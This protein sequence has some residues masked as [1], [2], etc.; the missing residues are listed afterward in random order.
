MLSTDVHTVI[1]SPISV[2]I[3]VL[4]IIMCKGL[5]VILEGFKRITL[6]D[7]HTITVR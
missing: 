5:R 2:S 3:S 6:T 1:N 4:G 7:L